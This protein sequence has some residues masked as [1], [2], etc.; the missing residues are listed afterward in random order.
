MKFVSND[1]L[2]CSYNDGSITM[3]SIKEKIQTLHNAKGSQFK[4]KIRNEH[5]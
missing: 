3:S 4:T 2:I 5:Y 1:R